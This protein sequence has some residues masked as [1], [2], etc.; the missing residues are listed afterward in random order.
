MPT[1]TYRCDDHGDFQ[2]ELLFAEHRRTSLCPNPSCSRIAL[3]VLN[4]HYARPMPEHYSDALDTVVKSERHYKD[5]LK[6]Q[7]DEYSVRTGIE[8]TFDMVDPTDPVAAGVVGDAGFESQER[9]HHDMQ[10][11]ADGGHKSSFVMP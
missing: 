11:A 3:Q 10:V 1:Y 2:R 4:F 7:A 9:V 5:E 8:T 6:R